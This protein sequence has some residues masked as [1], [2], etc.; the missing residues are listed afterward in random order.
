MC[1]TSHL[2]ERFHVVQPQE[3]AGY[4]WHFIE[5]VS[6]LLHYF[7]FHIFIPHYFELDEKLK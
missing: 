1:S 3:H 2:T 5:S 7:E 4:I 6:S